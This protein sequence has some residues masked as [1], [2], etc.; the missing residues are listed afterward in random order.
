MTSLKGKVA[1]VTL[2]RPEKLNALSYELACELDT[3][4]GEIEKDDGLA[5][6]I[7]TGAGPRAFAAVTRACAEHCASTA[8][9]YLMHVCGVQVIAAAP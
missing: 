9:I 7:L 1:I 4:L 8:M 6:V 3:E 2:N 5:V